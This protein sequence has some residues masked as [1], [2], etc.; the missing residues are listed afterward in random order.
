MAFYLFLLVNAVLFI[1]PAELI[2]ELASVPIYEVLIL[3]CTACALFDLMDQ[4]FSRDWADQPLT[5]ILL[6]LLALT[7][8][9]AF[10]GI[11]DPEKGTFEYLKV[12]IYYFLLVSVINTPQRLNLFLLAI[13]LFC[14]AV[15]AMAVLNYHEFI[16]LENLDAMEDV[17]GG[18]SVNEMV[19]LRLRGTGIFNDPND[20]GKVFVIAFPLT[21]YWLTSKNSNFMYRV[22]WILALVLFAYGVYL[23]KSR[24]GALAVFF[25]LMVV[26]QARYGWGRVLWFVLPALPLLAIVFVT[27]SGESGDTAQL[28]LQVWASAFDHLKGSVLNFLFGIG[29]NEYANKSWFVAHNSFM[30]SYVE[31]G[32]FGG[33]LFMGAFAYSIWNLYQ[34]NR[35]NQSGQMDSPPNHSVEHPILTDPLNQHGDYFNGAFPTAYPYSSDQGHNIPQ[36]GNLATLALPTDQA[37]PVKVANPM[38]L[39]MA[40]ILA[41]IAAGYAGIMMTIS[42]GFTVPTYMVLGLATCQL[43]LALPTPMPKSMRFNVSQLQRLFLMSVCFLVVMYV[44]LRLFVRF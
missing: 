33:T 3:S 39:R 42:C 17:R 4:F 32:F 36:S 26:V 43:R 23:T 22:F 8:V 10:L 19:H 35:M 38:L 20:F 37:N 41:G 24:G 6:S 18:G 29:I 25:G 16:E 12:V 21:V 9:Q 28:R 40:P 15:V 2:P 27:R 31:L 11:C 34:L 7:G 14:V 13:S 5:L 44:G 1:R 30:H